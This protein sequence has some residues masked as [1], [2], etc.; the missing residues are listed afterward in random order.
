MLTDPFPTALLIS[1]KLVFFLERKKKAKER[2]NLLSLKEAEPIHGKKSAELC[3]NLFSLYYFNT[4][5]VWFLS[6]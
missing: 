2:K 1:G 6:L 4:F 3:I 5:T